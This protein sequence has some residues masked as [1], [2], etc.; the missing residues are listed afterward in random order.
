MKKVT[1]SEK[2]YKKL[3]RKEK[4]V[5]DVMFQVKASIEDIKKGRIKRVA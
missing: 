5:D 2:E 3:K 4:I 1:I